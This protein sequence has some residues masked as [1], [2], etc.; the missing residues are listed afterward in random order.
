MHKAWRC[1]REQWG[2]LN[3]LESLVFESLYSILG[4]SVEDQ[5]THLPPETL[6]DVNLLSNTACCHYLI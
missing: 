4:V 6:Y 5:H 1:V 2:I 3:F